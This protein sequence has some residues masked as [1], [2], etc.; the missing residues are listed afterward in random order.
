[1]RVQ[2]PYRKEVYVGGQQKLEVYLLA[3]VKPVAL[4]YSCDLTA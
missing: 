3:E 1:M 2:M 4:F